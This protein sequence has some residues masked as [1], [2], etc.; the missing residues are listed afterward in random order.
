[1]WGLNSQTQDQE[2]YVLPSFKDTSH[3]ELRREGDPTQHLTATLSS[4]LTT[5]LPAP[6]LPSILLY[7]CFPLPSG[8]PY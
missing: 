4:L 1:M 3:I 7:L 5:P 2:S 6:D 8:I